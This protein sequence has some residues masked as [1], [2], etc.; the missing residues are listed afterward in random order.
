MTLVA[1]LGPGIRRDHPCHPA[2]PL[3]RPAPPLC[4]PAPPILPSCAAALA[5]LRHFPC[6]PV[7]PPFRLNVQSNRRGPPCPARRTAPC[8][9]QPTSPR[10]SP[11]RRESSPNASHGRG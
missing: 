11:S 4:R 8:D 1:T 10:S 6:H 5:V 3:C 7:T 9:C 2:P